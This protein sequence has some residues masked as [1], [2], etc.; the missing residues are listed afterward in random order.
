MFNLL[1]FG[2]EHIGDSGGGFMVT[3]R[4]MKAAGTEIGSM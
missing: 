2:R 1:L 4:P 3:S